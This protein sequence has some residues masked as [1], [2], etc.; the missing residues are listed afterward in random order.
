MVTL[1]HVPTVSCRM[2][3]PEFKS[4]AQL[5]NQF[6]SETEVTRS[7]QCTFFFRILTYFFNYCCNYYFPISLST[8]FQ[9]CKEMEGYFEYPP[10]PSPLK[11]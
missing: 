5:Q 11:S 8:A 1:G 4:V 3:V 6:F 9:S 7:Q 2:E 10:I